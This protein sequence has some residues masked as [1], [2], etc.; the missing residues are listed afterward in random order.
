MLIKYRAE[1]SRYFWTK[2][3]VLHLTGINGRRKDNNDESFI[4]TVKIPIFQRLLIISTFTIHRKKK[5]LLINWGRSFRWRPFSIQLHL[6]LAYIGRSF[7]TAQ[8]HDAKHG[9]VSWSITNWSYNHMSVFY[10]LDCSLFAS[11][12]ARSKAASMSIYHITV[13]ESSHMNSVLIYHHF[14]VKFV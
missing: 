11:Y 4:F 1:H 13:V 5:P 8:E 2:V 7:I 9:R 12:D 14:H 6:A 10:L 3:N